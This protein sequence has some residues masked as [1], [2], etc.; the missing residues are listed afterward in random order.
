MGEEDFQG[1]E[2]ITYAGNSTSSVGKKTSSL[3]ALWSFQALVPGSLLLPLGSFW[4]IFFKSWSIHCGYPHLCLYSRSLLGVFYFK[5]SLFIESLKP[6]ISVFPKWLCPKWYHLLPQSSTLFY[7]ICLLCLLHSRVQLITK[8]LSLSW[9]FFSPLMFPIYLPY[10]PF[11]LGPLPILLLPLYLAFCHLILGLWYSFLF[12]VPGDDFYTFQICYATSLL[13]P[14]VI[15]HCPWQSWSSYGCRKPLSLWSQN[16]F[17]DFCPNTSLFYD[18][19]TLF[20][21]FILY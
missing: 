21:T 10:R 4:A 8:S 19:I 1:R 2:D 20:I 3:R 12:G 6:G 5:S 15:S 18:C 14:L 9:D 7:I 17:L 13:K 16:I 11:L